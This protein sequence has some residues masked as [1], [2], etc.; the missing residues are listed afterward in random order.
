MWTTTR[1][2]P[3]ETSGRVLG[4]SLTSAG[5]ILIVEDEFL[6]ALQLEDILADGGH[7]VIG[8]VPDLASLERLG[9]VPDVALVDLNLR[10]GLT[11]PAIA[12]D[13]AGRYGSRVIYVTAN[14][15]QIDKP[16]PTAVGVVQKPFTRQAILSAISYALSGCPDSGRPAELEP[17]RQAQ[18]G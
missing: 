14:P 6:V 12:R 18:S 4:V 7:A 3:P 5:K 16:A 8:T 15:G 13:I 11:G 1:A 10:D 9:E 17:L 2:S